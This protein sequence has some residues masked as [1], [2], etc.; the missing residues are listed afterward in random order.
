VSDRIGTIRTMLVVFVAQAAMM[1][2][3]SIARSPSLLMPAAAFVG[4]SY[5]A[6]LALFP[7]TTAG[8]FGTR[9]MGVNYG[10]VFTAW[11]VGGV[12]GSMTAG[13]IVDSTHSYAIAYAV[14][15][16]LCL[17]AAGLTFATK[18]PSQGSVIGAGALAKPAAR[19]AA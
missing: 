4:F 8:Y 5:G 12:F 17:I 13:S 10:L 9:N 7:S 6:N 16:G 2:L 18:P 1:G 3:L 11:G 19:E 14:A 15:A